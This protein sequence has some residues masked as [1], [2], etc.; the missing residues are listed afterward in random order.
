MYWQN[1]WSKPDK[2]RPLKDN[3]LSIRKEHKDYGYRRIYREL[4]KKDIKI[5]KKKVQR[6]CQN[7]QIQVT[8]Y[9]KKYTSMGIKK[10]KVY[11]YKIK[12]YKIV[13]GKK[14]YG[15]FSGIKKIK[16]K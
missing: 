2:D 7:L 15:D 12:A 9:S 8:S 6:I 1:K 10:G 5:N 16:A 13:K 4:R 14:V 11:S 3:I